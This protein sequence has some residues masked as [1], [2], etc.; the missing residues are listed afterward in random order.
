MPNYLL[1]R[2]DLE[3][4]EDN[5]QETHNK[6]IDV[7]TDGMHLVRKESGDR[8]NVRISH[9]KAF[10]LLKGELVV[11]DDLPTEL[12]QGLF[13]QPGSHPVLVRLATAPG[14]INDD[15]KLNTVRGMAINIFNVP[16]KKLAG[17]AADTQDF[18]LDTGKEFINSGPK[19]FLQNF[20]PNA[21]IAPRLS[22]T[23][24]GA[25]SDASRMTNAAL[26]AVGL[27]SEKLDLFGHEKKHPMAEA[28]YSQTPYRYGDYVAKIGVIPDT[29]GLKALFEQSYDPETPDAFREATNAFFRRQTVEFVVAIQLNTGLDDM[30]IE[31]AQAKWSEDLSQYQPVARLLL[32]MQ[33]AFDAAKN[34]SFEDLSFSAAH[35]LEAHRPLG[36]INRARVVVYRALSQ[37]RRVENNKSTEEIASAD[38]IGEAVAP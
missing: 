28:Y 35:A 7:M 5:E 38:L 30:P 32:P 6:I 27:N 11:R 26:N 29:P 25:V 14:E 1:Y 17:H 8:E 34:A 13:S 21:T 33:T 4:V 3:T 36:G 2:D 23:I 37:K 24:K 19:A 16:G 18:V 9:A 20:K 31:D 12:A 10:G 15:S 22:D